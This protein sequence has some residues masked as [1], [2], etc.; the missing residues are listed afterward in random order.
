MQAETDGGLRR[1]RLKP[2]HPLARAAGRGLRFIVLEGATLAFFGLNLG[3]WCTAAPWWS[4]L[5]ACGV[6]T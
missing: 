3:S 6:A 1:V 5:L 4:A 2:E